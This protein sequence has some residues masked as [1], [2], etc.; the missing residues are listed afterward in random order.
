M[1]SYSV[2]VNHNG[3]RKLHFVSAASVEEAMRAARNRFG[4]IVIAAN[5]L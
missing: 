2:L 4:G 5:V 3:L 1:K